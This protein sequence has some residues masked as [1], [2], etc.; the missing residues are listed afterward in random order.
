MAVELDLMDP[1]ISG[2]RLLAQEALLRLDEFRE[3][4]AANPAAALDRATDTTGDQSHHGYSLK[5]TRT[6]LSRLYASGP[7]TFLQI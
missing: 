5:R 6:T 7:N 1:A 4:L 3:R 2:R